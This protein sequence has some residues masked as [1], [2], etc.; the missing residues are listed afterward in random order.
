MIAMAQTSLGRIARDGPKRIPQLGAFL[1]VTSDR[2]MLES[3][4]SLAAV[5]LNEEGLPLR[6]ALPLSSRDPA[7]LA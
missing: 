4:G 1:A 7:K 2:S 3:C 6:A 5:G